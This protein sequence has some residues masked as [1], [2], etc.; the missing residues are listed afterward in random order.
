ML[1][2]KMLK[3]IYLLLCLILPNKT[4]R[5]H[6]IKSLPSTIST[7]ART[8]PAFITSMAVTKSDLS[9][10]NPDETGRSCGSVSLIS[11]APCACSN[12]ETRYNAQ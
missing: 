7:H 9:G 12:G 6:L 1:C 8:D 3:T 10:Q 4:N 5:I 2:R 11:A